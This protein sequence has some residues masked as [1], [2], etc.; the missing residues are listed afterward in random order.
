MTRAYQTSRARR[1]T[2]PITIIR[3]RD[4]TI[5]TLGFTCFRA[6]HIGNAEFMVV[7]F[8]DRKNAMSAFADL[9]R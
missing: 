7:A 3:P 4:P 6:M 2:Q 5:R 8:S 9:G 1:V